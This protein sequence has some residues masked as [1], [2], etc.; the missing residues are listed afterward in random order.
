MGNYTVILMYVL[1]FVALYFIL[2]RPQQQRE[3]KT[4]EMRSNITVGNKITTIGGITGTVREIDEKNFVLEV[5]PDA[6]LLTFEKWAIG[7]L[8]QDAVAE[9]EEEIIE[10]E[11]DGPQQ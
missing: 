1:V 9:E 3:K 11:E 6:T 7:R 5:G 4:K 2:I 8:A 10:V